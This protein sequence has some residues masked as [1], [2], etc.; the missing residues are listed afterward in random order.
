MAEGTAVTSNVY[1][2]NCYNEP[3][4]KLLVG[5]NSAG[6]IAGW[7]TVAGTKYTAAELAVPRSKYPDDAKATF[8][9]GD[10]DIRVPWDS[11]TGTATVAIPNPTSSPISLDD[12]LILFITRNEAILMTTRGF[13]QDTF[14]VLLKNAL[15]ELV[16]AE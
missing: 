11:F 12:D 7:S 13:V 5:G 2:F 4:T 9:I 16:A 6:D 14:K 1:V 15:G 3:I 10:N 8:A